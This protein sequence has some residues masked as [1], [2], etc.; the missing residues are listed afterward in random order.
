MALFAAVK[1][2]EY[3]LVALYNMAHVDRELGLWESASELYE[4]TTPLAQRIGQSDIEIGAVAGEGLCLLELGRVESTLAVR[5]ADV[6]RR[7]ESRPDW[8][9]GREVAEALGVRLDAFDGKFE[10]AIARFDTAVSIAEGADFYNAA[11]LIAAC[12]DA[13]LGQFDRER[14][15]KLS[16]H[17]YSTSRV[18]E[19]GYPEMTR[20]YD[21]L[22]TLG[23]APHRQ[24]VL[25]WR[26]IRLGNVSPDRLVRRRFGAIRPPTANSISHYGIFVEISCHFRIWQ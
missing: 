17:R 9:Q 4:A 20:R 6:R 10:E 24:R 26:Y 11:W 23:D 13:L 12:A 8:F 15:I 3:Q 19:L 25:I 22:W 7:M 16:I 5:C 21:L 18:R 14:V 1:H 2:S